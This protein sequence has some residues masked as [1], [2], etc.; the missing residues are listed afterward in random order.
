MVSRIMLFAIIDKKPSPHRCLQ[1]EAHREVP[2]ARF[3]P[4]FQLLM[5]SETPANLRGS[6]RLGPSRNPID[7]QSS[8]SRRT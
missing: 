3:I 7:R 6:F 2:P 8:R 4:T 1:K 5:H